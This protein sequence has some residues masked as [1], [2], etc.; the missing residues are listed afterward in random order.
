MAVGPLSP[1][2][3]SMFMST[4][5]LLCAI[6]L[7]L[8]PRVFIATGPDSCGCAGTKEGSAAQKKTVSCERRLPTT[9][10]SA[11]RTRAS[12]AWCASLND[13]W[14]HAC[15]G[16]HRSVRVASG[17]AVWSLIGRAQPCSSTSI[18]E[19]LLR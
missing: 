6:I 4:C 14:N 2:S 11:A 15:K 7:A 19:L 3:P 17:S 1:A 5:S 16:W 10:G 12:S 8:L 18:G 9:A 13:I